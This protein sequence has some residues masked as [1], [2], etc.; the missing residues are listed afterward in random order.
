MLSLPARCYSE[1]G[2]Q[3]DELL[4]QHLAPADS[5]E[6][7]IVKCPGI[8]Y[9]ESAYIGRDPSGMANATSQVNDKTWLQYNRPSR[10][11]Y[12]GWRRVVS[13]P[14]SCPV[15]DNQEHGK[16]NLRVV[17]MPEPISRILASTGHS[18]DVPNN[19]IQHLE[20]RPPYQRGYP[21]DLPQ[22]PSPPSSPDSIIII[23]SDPQLPGSIFQ[24]DEAENGTCF[25]FVRKY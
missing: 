23:G 3:T 25:A 12:D 8:N 7:A 21:L 20:E 1:K 10:V 5:A 22:T 16:G 19:H 11:S 2:V 17:S 24:L 13:L 18:V 15:E 9:S 4:S 6:L 14:E